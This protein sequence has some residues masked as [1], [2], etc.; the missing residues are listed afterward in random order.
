MAEIK[1]IGDVLA[2]KIDKLYKE[3]QLL[4]NLMRT[5]PVNDPCM[6]KCPDCKT[7]NY[8]YQPGYIGWPK[9]YFTCNFC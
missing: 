1:T 3:I 6:K 5:D 7:I 4:E 8:Q 9:S 2:Y